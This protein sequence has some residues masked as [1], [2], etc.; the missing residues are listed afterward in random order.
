[1]Q[2]ELFS[3]G[4]LRLD[5]HFIRRKPERVGVLNRIISSC[6]DPLIRR[7]TD[8]D[9]LNLLIGEAHPLLRDGLDTI[10]RVYLQDLRPRVV[11]AIQ[12]SNSVKQEEVIRLLGVMIYQTLIRLVIQIR[13]AREISI[14]RQILRET[15]LK[16]KCCFAKMK[17]MMYVFVGLLLG[18]DV[19]SRSQVFL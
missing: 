8:I 18:C 19:G 3:S 12:G 16:R 10:M 9:E 17:K 6:V 14:E 13:Q 4:I 15:T 1:L 11:A 7:L 2:D 5:R